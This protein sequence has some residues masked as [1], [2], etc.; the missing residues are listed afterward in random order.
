VLTIVAMDYA[1]Q[2]PASVPAGLTT[3]RLVNR[4]RMLHHVQL[5]RLEQ[6]KTVSDMLREWKPGVAN[7]SYLTGAGGPTA[8]LGGETLEG[9]VVLQPGRYAII[10]WVPAAD[11]QLHLQKGMMGQ[12]E[13]LPLPASASSGAPAALPR[14]DV[15]I[16]MMDYGYLVPAIRP[17]RQS[18]RVENKGPQAHELV[19]V[20]L[21]R[22]RTA[23]DA[24]AWAEHGQTGDAPGAMVGGV[25]ALSAGHSG[26]FTVPFTPG[27]YALIC[28]VPDQKDGKG[29]PHTTY[30]MLRQF[31]VR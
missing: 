24:A 30:G 1:F 31:T 26:Q 20:R 15:T 7:P 4:G 25:A 13:V 28:F 9:Q 16:T 3:V 2:V 8:A 18:V 10:C 27:E 21:K 29:H 23:A 17:G 6:G 12:F 11:G 22:G 5:N 14:A 19:M